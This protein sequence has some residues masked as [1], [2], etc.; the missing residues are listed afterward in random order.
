VVP[1]ETLKALAEIAR[2]RGILL[3]ADEIYRAFHHDETPRSAAEFNDDVLVVDGFGKTYGITG[4][5]LG[6]AHGPQRL[7][8]EMAKIQQFTFVCAPSIVQYAGLA[9]LDVDTAPLAAEYR[10]KR[11]MVMK[12]LA[13][14]FDLVK[15][16]GAFYV[17]PRAPWGTASEFVAEAIRNHLLIIPGVTFSRV[18]THFRISIAAEDAKLASGIEILNRIAQRA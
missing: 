4:W 2:E 9:A 10:Q 14:R 16:G 1:L 7:I 13:E 18:D 12:G 17:F 8:D 5:R 15:P 6:Y 11:D 3:I